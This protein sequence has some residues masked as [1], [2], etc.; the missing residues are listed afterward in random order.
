LLW[1]AIY[2]MKLPGL[3]TKIRVAADWLIALLLPPDLA[4]LSL[5]RMSGFHEQHFTPG[6]TVFHQGDLG[7]FVYVIQE[8]EC[9]VLRTVDGQEQKLAELKAG[10]YFGEMAVL[11][12]ASR[13]ATIRA[14]TAM[15][16]LLIPKSDFD[17]LKANVPA[18]GEV[19]SALAR[20][21]GG[22]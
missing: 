9:D 1:R 11:S 5:A 13:N 4:Q 20:K 3:N 17:K 6:E 15:N 16:V 12:D 7:D 14:R 18:F 22:E 8:G 2:L 19:F 21:R 10:D